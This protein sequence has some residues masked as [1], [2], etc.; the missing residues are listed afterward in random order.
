MQGPY[1]KG[2]GR[3][4]RGMAGGWSAR[5]GRCTLQEIWNMSGSQLQFPDWVLQLQDTADL[6]GD[7]PPV[8]RCGVQPVPR[9][10][11]G[12]SGTAPGGLHL[13]P[14]LWTAGANV[15]PHLFLNV[16]HLENRNLPSWKLVND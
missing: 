8:G 5:F 3:H 4:G 14:S 11:L 16:E 12:N 15:T 7:H 2:S 9:S 13:R 10:D 6:M 1:G